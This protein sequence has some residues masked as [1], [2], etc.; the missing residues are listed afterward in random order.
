MNNQVKEEATPGNSAEINIRV[1]DQV[2][3]PLTYPRRIIM[4]YASS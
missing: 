1:K 3:M 4:L 2:T